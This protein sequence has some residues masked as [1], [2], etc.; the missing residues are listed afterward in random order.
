MAPKLSEKR[1]SQLLSRLC[2]TDAQ[3]VYFPVRHHSPAAAALVKRWIQQNRPQTV[4]IEGPSDYNEYLDELFLEHKLPIAIY[5][6]FRTASFHSG[7]YYPFC[8]YSPE[9]LALSEARRVSADVRFIDLPWAESEGDER[10]THRYADAELRRGQYVAALCRRLHVDGF[11]DLWDRMVES[12]L[13]LSI[14][15]YLTRTHEFCL[16]TRCWEEDVSVSDRRRE[17]F[18]AAQIENALV[19][20][21]G[22][23]LVVTGGFHS[24]A[25]VARV[26][27]LSCEGLGLEDPP[28]RH[29]SEVPK[30]LDKGV[31]LTTYS[32][33]RLDSLRGYNAGMP[34]P[35][36]YRQ[37]WKQREASTK[38]ANE[39]EDATGD[40]GFDHQPLLSALVAALRRRKQTLSTADLIAVETSAR[41][42]AALRGRKFVWRLDLVDGVSSALIKDELQF[43]ATSPFLE[44]VYEVLRGSRSGRLAEGV[45]LPPLVDAI[46]HELDSLELLPNGRSKTIEL[47]LLNPSDV[48]RSR[49]LHRL[50]VLEIQGFRCTG[51]TDFLQ[52]EE[53]QDLWE[54]WEIHRSPNLEASCIEAARYGTVL[55]HAVAAKLV[56]SACGKAQTASAACNLLITA[57]RCGVNAITDDLIESIQSLVAKEARFEEVGISLGHLL[58]LYCFDEAFG[59]ARLE[60]LRDLISESFVRALWLFESLGRTSTADPRVLMAI[61][62]VSETYRRLDDVIDVEEDELVGVLS[63]IHADKGKSPDVRGAAAGILWCVGGTTTNQVLEQ[64]KFFSSPSEL[65]DFLGGLFRLAREV[66]Q[67]DPALVRSIDDLLVG[68]DS[69]G[70]QT[71]LPALRL[72]FTSF[73]PREKNQLLTTLFEMLGLKKSETPILEAANLNTAAE[74]LALEEKT[75]ETIQR[76]G[77]E[78]TDGWI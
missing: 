21:S 18:M 20:G 61:E 22:R 68:F 31:A 70:F 42:L 25:L 55:D 48:V 9:W 26:D 23:V 37:V 43:G 16:S 72:A 19:R 6:Y 24:S 67:R 3:V 11:D 14:E 71:A 51:G 33:H 45:R 5:S 65:G 28:P 36:F 40:V 17:S 41:G 52:R 47:D 12:Q 2:D 60:R 75:E 38:T 54:S 15:D 29:D 50:R 7:V 1:R 74:A 13:D 27:G 34:N 49:F 76:Y 30:V 63:R 56:E 44:A 58:F 59:T 73:T 53:M 39:H 64:M 46:Q 77:L 32:Y 57:S 69:E 4:L 62:N 35:G 66:V 10:Q 8:E 78:A